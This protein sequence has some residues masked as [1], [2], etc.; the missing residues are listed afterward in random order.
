MKNFQFRKIDAFLQQLFLGAHTEHGLLCVHIHISIRSL[1]ACACV[2]AISFAV[3]PLSRHLG[4]LLLMTP[5]A[6]PPLPSPHFWLF[7]ICSK[8]VQQQW[9]QQQ[10]VNWQSGANMR[11]NKFNLYYFFFVAVWHK[12]TMA[13]KKAHTHALSYALRGNYF[14]I[15]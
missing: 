6:P 1:M 12:Q 13:R 15:V 7:V 9:T 14:H 4:I 2:W 11:A 8:W 10:I 5:P 3:F